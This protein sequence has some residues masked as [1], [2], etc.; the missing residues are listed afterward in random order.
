MFASALDASLSGQFGSTAIPSPSVRYW[1]AVGMWGAVVLGRQTH[2]YG[3]RQGMTTDIAD[4]GMGLSALIL[5][6]LA[7]FTI[8]GWLTH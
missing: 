8:L 6:L 3:K 7:G 2:R 5:L 4:F 1:I